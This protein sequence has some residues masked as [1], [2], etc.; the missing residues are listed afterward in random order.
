[1]RIAV[2]SQNFRTIT[3]HAGMT[4]RFLIYEAGPDGEP[5]ERDR[6]DLPRDQ[7]L[8]ATLG[9]GTNHHPL[10]QSGVNALVT[11]SA[12]HKLRQRLDAMGIRV[13]LTGET[14]PVA[15]ARA[16]F[17]GRPLPEP[18]PHDHGHGHGHAHTHGG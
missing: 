6:V 4:R 17:A 16:L 5:V 10:F 13:H 18:A 9:Q 12:G 8:H 15:A 11:Q 3:G 1:M 7:S 2:T 14:D